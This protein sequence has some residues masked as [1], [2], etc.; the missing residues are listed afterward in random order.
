MVLPNQSRARIPLPVK[1]MKLDIIAEILAILEEGGRRLSGGYYACNDNNYEFH[2]DGG[3]AVVYPNGDKYW[4]KHGVIHREGGPAIIKSD[5]TE[6][7]ICNGRLHREGGPA[8]IYPD[9]R[10]LW[11]LHG[12]R[13]AD[14]D[15][16]P[17]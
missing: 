7:W 15:S 9:G 4:Y 3:P 12:I 1:H 13:Q 2:R 8:A 17:A 14:P 10:R 16:S 5:G 6:E 11:F